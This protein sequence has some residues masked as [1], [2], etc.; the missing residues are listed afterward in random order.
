MMVIHCY[1]VLLLFHLCEVV[2]PGKDKDKVTRKRPTTVSD[3]C[4]M[5][6]LKDWANLGDVILRKSCEAVNLSP[7]G[8][9]MAMAIR[10]EE[11]YH[12]MAENAGRDKRVYFFILSCSLV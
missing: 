8:G 3:P 11:F 5:R 12:Q 2:H 4:G 6:S 10:F 7:S 9:I 1:L